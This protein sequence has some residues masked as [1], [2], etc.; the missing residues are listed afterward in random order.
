M[1]L[2]RSLGIEPRPPELGVWSL[3]LLVW[4]D[5]RTKAEGVI[6]SPFTSAAPFQHEILYDWINPTYLD[7]EY[8][9]QIQEE[10]EESSE[11]LLKEFLQVGQKILSDNTMF[12]T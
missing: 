6:N 7:M 2:V 5:G 10:F 8:Q 1:D 3:I 12:G 9:A 11:I 4:H